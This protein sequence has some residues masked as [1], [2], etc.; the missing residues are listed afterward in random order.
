M[1][2]RTP[3]VL[4]VMHCAPDSGELCDGHGAGHAMAPI[5]ERV[6]AATPS[7]WRD[8]IVRAVTAD[9]W[10]AIGLLTPSHTANDADSDKRHD[11]PD[12]TV[13]GWNH[14]DRTGSLRAGEPVAVH[15][16]YHTLAIGRE[17]VNILIAAPIA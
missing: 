1:T 8:G 4:D 13:W 6:A 14:L 12:N 5:Q 16:L 7:K 9:G 10:I 2:N 3:G 11:T 15:E 17:R